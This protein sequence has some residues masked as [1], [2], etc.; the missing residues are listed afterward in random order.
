M[1]KSEFTVKYILSELQKFRGRTINVYLFIEDLA[2][3]SGFDLS[4][5]DMFVDKFGDKVLSSINREIRR[6]ESK[7]IIPEFTVTSYNSRIIQR[8]EY[9]IDSDKTVE[10][11]KSIIKYRDLI[12]DELKN[13]TWRDFEFLIKYVLKANYLKEPRVTQG[14]NDQGIDFYAFLE[15]EDHVVLSNRFSKDIKLRIVGQAKHSTKNNKVGHAKVASFATEIRKLRRRQ[16]TDYFKCLDEDFYLNEYPILGIF[17]T[18]TNYSPK[19]KNF[20]DEYGII[21]WDGEQ[22]SEDLAGSSFL[23]NILVNEKI[24]FNMLLS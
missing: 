21:I 24:D 5:S 23:K 12:F 2:M 20:A 22:I 10:N 16:N 6:C 7:F 18:N 19:S 1:K 3:S 15:L 9:V 11:N 4:A 8:S 14:S 13:I 17:I